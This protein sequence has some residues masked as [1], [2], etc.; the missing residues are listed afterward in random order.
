MVIIMHKYPG[1]KIISPENR[2]ARNKE[3][4]LLVMNGYDG[5][6]IAKKMGLA[7]KYCGVLIKDV[8]R[9]W[10][11]EKYYMFMDVNKLT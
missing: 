10:K 4:L 1:F 9:Y 2:M 6:H 3:I 11:D 8:K 7:Y 5:V